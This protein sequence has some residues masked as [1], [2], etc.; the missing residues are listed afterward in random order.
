MPR[1]VILT[2]LSVEYLAVRNYLIDLR[3]EIHDSG[4]IYELG[5][6]ITDKQAWDVVIVEV[7]TGNTRGAI[8][9]ERAIV[10]YNPLILLF[11]GVA[12]GIRD[13]EIGDV[14]AATKVYNYEA[15]KAAE[16]LTTRPAV[17]QSA[18]NLVRIARS[19][20]GKSDWLQR[21]SSA[22]SSN[23]SVFVAPIASGDK[24]ITST[25]SETFRFLRSNYADA[26]AVDMEGFGF[27]S[28]VFAYPNIE[29]LVIRGISDLID[30]K[31]YA[32]P[33]HRESVQKRAAEHA[34]AFA[35]EVLAN[36]QPE[37]LKTQVKDFLAQ[38]PRNDLAYGKDLLSIG[39]EVDALAEVLLLR[40]LEP[41]IAVG[42]LGGWGSGKSFVM[43]L[44]Q[45]K[46]TEI[47]SQK[48]R[49]EQ[50]WGDDIKQLSPYVGHVYQ[51]HFDAW[52]YARSNLWAS[53]METV[54]FEL[55]RQ[56]TLEKQLQK[57][58]ASPL[59]GGKVWQALNDMREEE[60]QTLLEHEL[61][62]EVLN[63]W[64]KIVDQ[65]QVIDLLLTSLKK[66]NEKR[67]EI[68]KRKEKKL[69]HKREKL[70]QEASKI[71]QEVNEELPQEQ[72]LAT[73]LSPTGSIL[74]KAMGET[75]KELQK[76]VSAS[77]PLDRQLN[78]QDFQ[79]IQAIFEYFR[80]NKLLT[81][82]GFRRWTVDNWRLFLGFIIFSMLTAIGIPLFTIHVTQIIPKIVASLVPLVPA[83]I[84]GTTLIKKFLGWSSSVEKSFTAYQQSVEEQQQRIVT[85]QEEIVQL[86]EARLEE[87]LNQSGKVQAIKLSVKQL[88]AQVEEQ[89][90]SLDIIKHVS[91]PDFVTAQLEAGEYDKR[92]GLLQL[93]KKDL[94]ELT[95]KLTLP[96]NQGK[97]YFEKFEE[98]KKLFPRGA[99]RVVL[100][101]DDLDRCPP[102][103]VVEVL[104]AVQLLLKTPLFVVVL[105]IDERYIA[106]SLEKVYGGVLCRQGNPSG[107]DYIEKIIQIPYRVR[108]VIPS[109]V[110]MYLRDQMDLEYEVDNESLKRNFGEV[111]ELESTQTNYQKTEATSSDANFSSDD[112]EDL[113]LE[114]I[115]FTQ[116]EFDAIAR[117]CK[118]VVLSPRTIKRLINVYKL[119]KIIWFRL[120][121]TQHELEDKLLREAIITLLVISARYPDISR[122]LFEE[123]EL[124]FE[125]L[126]ESELKA[127]SLVEFFS[128]HYLDDNAQLKRDWQR[129][130]H[131]V[132]KTKLIPDI[133]LAEL[134]Q[135]TF[136]TVRSFSFVGDVG[137][138]PDDFLQNDKN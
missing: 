130:I 84:T 89:R 27:L 137:Y 76:E 124:K 48:L 112:V 64:E 28:A 118:Q 41:P 20:S 127:K 135:D 108:P 7:G 106:R 29:A 35:F 9:A 11:V 37:D 23:P 16:K 87:K 18:F 71:Q 63:K 132:K 85:H 75:L 125:E 39:I 52:T 44:M 5:R 98:L 2:A 99:A 62:E 26:V 90:K 25:T 97:Q 1:A 49:E 57:A 12:G 134:G 66:S 53:L 50:S 67:I 58:G 83:I 4:T 68:L 113:T 60:R 14:V 24:V 72:M 117:C 21:L 103:R 126:G 104:E 110:E 80:S 32:D 100:Y 91:L 114:V 95:E 81:W 133:S 109:T 115:K 31:K 43:H 73:V 13:V 123:I 45:K 121:K 6:F 88:E 33:E 65:Q 129:L 116:Y 105:A 74:H 56:L 15:A 94:A 22:S 77:I 59:N 3:R 96:K 120:K 40:N 51:I 17:A 93:V 36:I 47:R 131:D 55:N 42:I 38:S 82:S 54:F 136:N 79:Q 102:D 122:I 19:E 119:F 10:R 86:R 78:K 70:Q 8:E 107:L 61:D 46:M 111:L 69:K 92:L 128:E 138:D 30:N 101:I 34:S